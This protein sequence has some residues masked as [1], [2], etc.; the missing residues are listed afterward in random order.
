MT[1]NARQRAA[2]TTICET[3]APGDGAGIPSAAALGAVAI[4]EGLAAD[5]ERLLLKLGDSSSER[6]RVLFQALRS[7]ATTSYLLAPGPTGTSPVWDAI[8]YPGAA[9]IR[10]TTEARAGVSAGG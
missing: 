8:G 3:F 10:S 9:G 1:L 6:K 5:R 4:A 2:L 7:I